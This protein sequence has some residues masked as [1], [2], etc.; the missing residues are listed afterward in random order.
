MKHKQDVNLL[1]ITIRNKRTPRTSFLL[2]SLISTPTLSSTASADDDDEEGLSFLKEAEADV[3]FESK[4]PHSDAKYSDNEDDDFE[5]YD[6]FK[7]PSSFSHE[8][9][10]KNEIANI[11][12]KDV[13]VLTDGNFNYFVN[14][15]KYVMVEFY[16]PWCGHCK[17]LAP[18]Y[19]A[20][21]WS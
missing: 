10:E 1:K 12:K 15:N 19:A 20:T 9:A 11:D 21:A 3:F 4:Y 5:N 6:D 17:A 8:E 16:A 18:E 14:E 13:V 2:F 7:V